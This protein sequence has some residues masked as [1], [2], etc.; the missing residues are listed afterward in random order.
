MKE[1][2]NIEPVTVSLLQGGS[3]AAYM[4]SKVAVGADLDHLKPPHMKPPD[5]DLTK[6]VN[7]KK[8][9]N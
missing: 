8:E 3:F 6:L 4:K 2:L 5:E 9:S 7:I 1:I